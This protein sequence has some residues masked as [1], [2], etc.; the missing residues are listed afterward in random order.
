MAESRPQSS[1]EK[2]VRQ[3]EKLLDDMENEELSLEESIQKFEQG[4]RLVKKCQRALD[5]AE[6]KIKVLMKNGDK[7]EL[8]DYRPDKE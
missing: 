2:E 3:L 4:V 1:F 6:Q 7:M 8:K 5:R